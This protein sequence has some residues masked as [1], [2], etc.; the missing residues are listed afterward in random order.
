MHRQ[1]MRAKLLETVKGL[2][3]QTQEPESLT[4]RSIAQAAG[5]NP[6]AINY[7]FGGK[8]ALLA[9]A[10]NSL[11]ADAADAWLR[12]QTP[13]HAPLNQLRDMLW[14]LSELMLRYSSFTRQT[15]PSVLL[16]GD[17]TAPRYI[18]PLIRAHFGA[19]RSER[20]CRVLSYELIS[21]TALAFLNEKAFCDYTGLDL[22]DAQGRRR[23]YE[24]QFD[25]FFQ[26]KGEAPD[27]P[28][29]PPEPRH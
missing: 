23:F 17:M 6:A 19:A 20:A 11:V 28:C 7:C 15:L 24:M 25:F 21:F 18:L 10:A 1:E 8:D 9:E 22:S 16:S 13:A 5:V 12:R 29:E 14:D 4:S 27:G 3:V 26:L 2:L